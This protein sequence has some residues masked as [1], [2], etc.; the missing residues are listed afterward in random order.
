MTNSNDIH[1]TKKFVLLAV[2]YS[3]VLLI[4]NILANKIIMPFGYTLPCAV[5]L[6]PIVYIISD[7]MTEVYGIAR[8]KLAITANTA[9]NLFMSLIFLLAV[10]IPCAPFADSTAFDSILGSTPR[11][12]IASLVSYFI[13]D[14][15]NSYSLSFFKAKLSNV[16]LLNLFLF[17]SICSSMLGQIFDTIGFITMAFY[18]TVPN[19]VLFQM[20][21]C[22]Y[23]VKIGYQIIVHPIMHFIVAWWKKSENID[24]VDNW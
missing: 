13:G 14:M 10:N 15:V 1:V 9:M 7:L 4:S 12:V 6:F 20:M 5:I 23:I 16:P 11:M 8:S 3:G 22:Q 2:A 21:F 17:R 19:D 24:V 18:G